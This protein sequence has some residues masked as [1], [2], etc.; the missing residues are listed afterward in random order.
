MRRGIGAPGENFSTMSTQNGQRRAEKQGHKKRKRNDGERKSGVNKRMKKGRQSEGEKEEG[1][2]VL[3]VE[4]LGWKGVSLENDEFDDFEELE[5]VD[6]DYVDVNGSKV[7]Q[8]KVYDV[9]V[10][11]Y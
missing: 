3:N 6:V 7:V 4:Q 9:F 5:G 1:G 8:F 11:G 2:K 10:R